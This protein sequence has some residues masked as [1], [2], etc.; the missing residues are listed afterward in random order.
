LQQL[1][2]TDANVLAPGSYGL[3]LDHYGILVANGADPKTNYTAMAPLSAND[4]QLLGGPA[5]ALRS[6]RRR[7]SAFTCAPGHATHARC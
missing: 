7:A 4:R 5:T 1:L 3:L 6:L 2:Q